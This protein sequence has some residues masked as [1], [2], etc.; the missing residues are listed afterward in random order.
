MVRGRR[1]PPVVGRPPRNPAEP[2]AKASP[3]AHAVVI[4]RYRAGH[5]GSCRTSLW[6]GWAIGLAHYSEQEFLAKIDELVAEPP[7]GS[8]VRAFERACALDSMGHPDQAVPLYR[9]A[10][11]RGLEGERRRRA[12]IQLASSLRN[13]G[14]VAEGLELLLAEREQPSDRLD[15]CLS[16]VLGSSSPIAVANGKPSRSRSPRSPGTC[17]A[18]SARWQTTLAC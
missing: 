16:A 6:E 10:L 9:H 3:L 1:E 8:G 15:D 5:P 12:V 13:L 14:Q 17:R 18:I 7:D 11:A 2:E 4:I